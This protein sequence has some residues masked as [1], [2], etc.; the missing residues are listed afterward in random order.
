MI[1]GRSGHGDTRTETEQQQ[2]DTGRHIR[3]AV[4]ECGLHGV[5]VRWSECEF[6]KVAL[7]LG[8]QLTS[9]HDLSHLGLLPHHVLGQREVEDVRNTGRAVGIL[10]ICCHRNHVPFGGVATGL[11]LTQTTQPFVLHS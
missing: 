3:R 10:F 8:D 6:G 9:S 7:D 2:P 11:G 4:D 1:S 5:S